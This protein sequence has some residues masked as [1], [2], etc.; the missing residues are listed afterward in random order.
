[1]L[2]LPVCICTT[3][4]IECCRVRRSVCYPFE[5]IKLSRAQ[6]DDIDPKNNKASTESKYNKDCLQ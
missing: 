1:M 4:A 5:W 6:D 2:P 3:I